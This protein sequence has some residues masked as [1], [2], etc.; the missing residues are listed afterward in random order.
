[1][2]YTSQRIR[3]LF[4]L[5]SIADTRDAITRQ[6]LT[7]W[8]RTNW[9]VEG[10]LSFNGEMV[11]G[12]VYDSAKVEI[13]PDANRTGAALVEKTLNAS[14]IANSVSLAD[15]QAG[16][17]QH[18]A[19]DIT[20]EEANFSLSGASG[21]FYMVVSLRTTDAKW[22]VAGFATMTVVESGTPK[23]DDYP[24]Q[25]GNIIPSGVSYDGSGQ[26]VL[27]TVADKLY[28]VAFGPNDTSLTNTPDTVSS[29]GNFTA[30]GTTVTLNG[31]ANALVTTVVR[32]KVYL[33]AEES[34]ARYLTN[35]RWTGAWN[36]GIDYVARDAVSYNGS[37]W[38]ALRAN[39]NV[40]PV[41]GDDWE[42]IAKGVNV[43]STSDTSLAIGVGSKT[44]TTAVPLDVAVGS[45]LLLARTSAPTTTFMAG[46]V[47]AI[48]GTSVT[49][50]ST[51]A[52]G[53]GTHTDWTVSLS[54]GRDNPKLGVSLTGPRGDVQVGTG[55][56]TLRAPQAM[57]LESVRASLTVASS[58]GV[59]TVDI[60]KNGTSILSTKLTI[61]ANEKTSM[62]AAV[63]AVIS[64]TEI[65]EDDEITFDVDTA[66]TNAK[67]LKVWLTGKP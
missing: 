5:S 46:Q 28:S 59:V 13:M 20:H 17:D 14:E 21:K 30:N 45:F 38:A 29:D 53:T 3:L 64:D 19:F 48:S 60:N 26:Y 41:V 18:F 33:T 8:K 50:A 63:E 31:T 58:S 51:N 62:T 66:G 61:D 25:G 27:T 40:A 57:L 52:A 44:F 67:G 1:M 47:T 49:I 54:G 2:Q 7:L 65:A 37:S 12:S 16:T 9:R 56:E 43:N 23:D 42:L 6:A 22:I 11:D 24:V 39:T 10:G 55:T 15:W 36:S 4:T 35:L 34:D 32:S